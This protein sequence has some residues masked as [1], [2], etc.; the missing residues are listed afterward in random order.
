MELL[1]PLPAH[2]DASWS[3]LARWLIHAHTSHLAVTR[4]T[5]HPSDRLIGHAVSTRDLSQR[6]TLLDPLQHGQP[7]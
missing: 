6:F 1:R 2:A 4:S 7:F 5:Q 3:I